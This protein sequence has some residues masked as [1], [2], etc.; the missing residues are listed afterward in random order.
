MPFALNIRRFKPQQVS[1]PSS[2]QIFCCSRDWDS[3]LLPRHP[4][5][6]FLSMDIVLFSDATFYAVTVQRLSYSPLVS[7]VRKY[8]AVLLAREP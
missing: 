6:S 7:A 5:I 8:G 2:G 3:H 4:V 1:S